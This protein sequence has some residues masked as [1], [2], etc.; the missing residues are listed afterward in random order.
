[1]R[2]RAHVLTAAKNEVSATACAFAIAARSSETAISTSKPAASFSDNAARSASRARE[3]IPRAKEALEAAQ[4]NNAKK[5][6]RVAETGVSAESLPPAAIVTSTAS[7]P[8]LSPVLDTL[9]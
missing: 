1:M 4:V 9:D 2:P 8:T 6:R 7:V 3:S 5:T